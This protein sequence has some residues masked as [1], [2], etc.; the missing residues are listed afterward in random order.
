VNISIASSGNAGEITGEDTL[1][2]GITTTDLDLINFD[3]TIVDWEYSLN[4]GN[5]WISTGLTTSSIT[6]NGITGNSLIRAIVE[7]APCGTDTSFFS[8][9][10]SSGSEAG[11]LSGSLTHCGPINNGQIITAGY[12]GDVIEWIQ[13]PSGE[14]NFS[15][16]NSQN[17]TL[18]YANNTAS[19]DYA[20]IVQFESCPPDTSDII[21]ITI[22]SAS[23]A[24]QII[25]ADTVCSNPDGIAIELNNNLGSV[26]GWE[27]SINGGIT[28]VSTGIT[29]ST[30]L[31]LDTYEN[32]E[33]RV[34]VQNEACPPDTSLASVFIHS[35]L[36]S[37]IWQDTIYVGDSIQLSAG[38]GESFEWSPA[39]NIDS[40]FSPNPIV[41]PIIN[42]TYEV[43]V[44][45]SNGC[46]TTSSHEI[47]VLDN[48]N[49]ITVN[50]FVTPNGDG[51]NDTWLI[52]NI[53]L[54]PTNSVIVFNVYG[55]II[56]EASPYQND[57]D[58]S[59]DNL[60][61][62]TYFYAVTTLPNTPPVKGTI[63]IVNSK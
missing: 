41:A 9:I 55:Q 56:F 44:T 31:Y 48:P 7:K 61:D 10:V 51:F 11:I 60:P 3:G 17:D 22:H 33:F 53:E 47:T 35:A 26:L 8:I 29:D 28:W 1:C 20:V 2:E 45:D 13:S 24:G 42:T 15:T 30:F 27:Y 57:W 21:S 43:E 37:F 12:V 32:P 46:F 38:M 5:S 16:I 50:N 39:L 34:I 36:E 18:A 25:V 14:D 54:F 49:V 4:N 58:I 6:I 59:A 19:L 62:G 52:K 63:T 23:D 40:I